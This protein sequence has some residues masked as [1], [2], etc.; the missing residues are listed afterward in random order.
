VSEG[1][2]S[3]GQFRVQSQG[4]RRRRFGLRKTLLGRQDAE[5]GA[6]LICIGEAGVSQC[7]GWI[8]LHGLLEELDALLDA[9]RRP[10]VQ[11]IAASQ[12]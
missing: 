6:E 11:C 5:N 4:R 7:K 10:L 12:V 3:F 8:G 2:V 9:R 1:C